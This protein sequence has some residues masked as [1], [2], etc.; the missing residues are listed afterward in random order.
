MARR[1]HQEL[2]G[3]RFGEWT[4]IGV[5]PMRKCGTTYW[6]CRCS[7]G[8][9]KPISEARI[10]RGIGKR[11][12]NCWSPHRS[13][14]TPYNSRIGE[15]FGS[16]VVLAIDGSHGL[17][18][19][20]CGRRKSIL[21]GNVVSGAT[22]SCGCKVGGVPT[23]GLSKSRMYHIWNGLMGRCL[24]EKNDAYANYGGRGITVC[25]RWRESIES[26]IADMGPRPRRHSV[27]RIDN[28]GGYWCGKCDE[29]AALGQPSN[30]RW[31]TQREQMN[32]TRRNVVVERDGL[33]MSVAEW[34]RRIKISHQAVYQRLWHGWT[35]EDA[36][37]TP[38][39]GKPRT[40]PSYKPRTCSI[41]GLPGHRKT[42]CIKREAA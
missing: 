30:C 11:C 9:E 38:R 2:A 36:A 27:D 10:K 14:P 6:L 42:T 25:R 4:V 13:K 12:R 31:A 24:N 21:M 17:C 22:R 1:S 20:D 39:G 5:R 19:C 37:T 29:C 8:T 40:A 28:D 23:H 18:A 34:G 7:C 33:R 35:L 3:Y 16:L 32:N 41:C 26:F 15:R